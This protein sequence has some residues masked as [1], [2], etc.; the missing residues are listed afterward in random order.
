MWLVAATALSVLHGW[1]QRMMR[2]RP[3]LA[4]TPSSRSSPFG[5]RA[6]SSSGSDDRSGC[7]DSDVPLSR[8]LLRSASGPGPGTTV[9]FI[10]PVAGEP[11]AQ[12]AEPPPSREPGESARILVL[13]DDPRMMRFVR[14][15]LSKAGY[16]PLV[17]G[18]PGELA[19]LILSEKP[20]LIP[21]IEPAPGSRGGLGLAWRMSGAGAG[22]RARASASPR[23][24]R[25]HRRAPSPTPSSPSRPP[26]R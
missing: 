12:A 25:A 26:R 21:G 4:Y 3:Q 22:S 24:R 11:G 7:R 15:A 20:R 8:L 13:D 5:A 6:R 1:F 17:T 10:L 16:V 18:E 14:D 19:H 9:T 23:P 2:L